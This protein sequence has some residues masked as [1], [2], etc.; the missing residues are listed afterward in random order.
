MTRLQSYLR[1]LCGALGAPGH[2][3]SRARGCQSHVRPCWP[4]FSIGISP[5][6]SDRCAIRRAAALLRVKSWWRGSSVATGPRGP[7]RQWAGRP[8]THATPSAPVGWR[9]PRWQYST[10][11]DR[12]P[13]GPRCETA[14][15]S[16]VQA[17][18]EHGPGA[19]HQERSE[20][21]VALFAD[22][23]EP[24]PAPTGV[25]PRREAQIARKVPS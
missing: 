20:I 1:P 18:R 13:R 17:V 3:G 6:R 11:G 2:D 15:S 10:L 24:P 12:R 21:P 23:A 22:R 7:R 9:S 5:R 4:S 8:A 14:W 25:F 16:P 19:M